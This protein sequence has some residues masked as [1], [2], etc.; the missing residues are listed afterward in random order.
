MSSVSD[1]TGRLV[2]L[3]AF[4]GAKTSGEAQLEMVLAQP[5]ESGKITAGIQKLVQRYLL[6]FATERGSLP[7]DE[8]RGT[9]FLYEARSGIFTSSVDVLGAFARAH[10]F[11][12]EN[13]VGEEV[14][15]DPD[16]E[17]LASAEV[18]SVAF[19][20]GSVSLR[21]R[22]TSLAGDT[23]QVLMPIGVTI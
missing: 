8:E 1:Y 10:S 18:E 4:D 13:L 9:N 16:D 6:E 22:I 7:Y 14:D 15:S 17:R 3:L 11:V 5:G 12:L 19:S 2:D 23:R 21:I 20:P